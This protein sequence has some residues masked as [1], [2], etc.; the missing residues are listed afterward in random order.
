MTTNAKSYLQC[1]IYLSYTIYAFLFLFLLFFFFFLTCLLV[2]VVLETNFSILLICILEKEEIITK[3]G[4]LF[5]SRLLRGIFK[6]VSLL[7]SIYKIG[8]RNRF[9]V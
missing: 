9:A 8:K 3:E 4:A 5:R 7:Y 2:L 6:Y 1:L